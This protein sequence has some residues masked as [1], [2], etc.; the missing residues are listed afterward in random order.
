MTAMPSLNRTLQAQPLRLALAA[1]VL[2]TAGTLALRADAAPP[3]HGPGPGAM[4]GGPGHIEHLLELA[5]AS[6][7]QRSQI[8]SIIKA[9]R[10]DLKPQR[11]ADRTLQQQLTQLLLQP[12][13]DARAAETLRQQ[14]QAQHDQSSKRWLQA[15]IDASRVLSAD[16]RQ[17]LGSQMSQRRALMER[18][19]AEREALDK[20]AR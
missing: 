2:A 11:D 19:R 12:S 15:M 13:I 14:I 3:P 8:Q 16:Q 18:Q 4:M 1:L 9:A 7:D 6:A 17:A 20:P 5:G 10:A